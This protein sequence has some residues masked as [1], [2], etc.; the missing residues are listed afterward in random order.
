MEILINT[1]IL[2]YE[3]SN[4]KK[5]HPVKWKLLWYTPFYSSDQQHAWSWK[6]FAVNQIKKVR[7]PIH[8]G[9]FC[10]IWLPFYSEFE[11]GIFPRVLLLKDSSVWIPLNVGCKWMIGFGLPVLFEGCLNNKHLFE[12]E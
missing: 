2:K 3:S 11:D 4:L 12:M 7:D 6:I 8:C 9:E 5:D 1:V 10:S